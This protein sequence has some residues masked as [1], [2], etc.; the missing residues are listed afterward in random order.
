MTADGEGLAID[1][2]GPVSFIQ[3]RR[4]PRV[5]CV[6]GIVKFSRPCY[7]PAAAQPGSDPGL[8]SQT[9]CEVSIM[10]RIEQQL[11]CLG[12]DPGLPLPPKIELSVSV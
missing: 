7:G 12:W 9:R 10:G 6:G 3:H 8:I 2:A 1:T 5:L 4:I 11:D